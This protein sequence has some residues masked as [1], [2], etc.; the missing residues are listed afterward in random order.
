M[1]CH[2]D[3][4]SKE[5]SRWW[6]GVHSHSAKSQRTHLRARGDQKNN[7][8]IPSRLGK[9]IEGA[10]ATGTREMSHPNSARIHFLEVRMPLSFRCPAHYSS[11]GVC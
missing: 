10:R 8:V 9:A 4:H 2:A 11:V 7:R 1:A 5:K 3:P 6:N